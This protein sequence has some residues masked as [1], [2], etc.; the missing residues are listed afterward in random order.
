ERVVSTRF[1]EFGRR[2]PA[3]LDEVA[4]EFFGTDEAKEAVARKVQYLFPAHEVEEF[5]ERFWQRIQH[6]RETEGRQEAERAAGE[7]PVLATGGAAPGG[8][9]TGASAA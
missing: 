5:T 6:W 1:E 3:D 7:R 2:R 9:A 8:A 4:W